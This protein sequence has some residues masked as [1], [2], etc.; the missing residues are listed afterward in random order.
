MLGYL[1]RVAKAEFQL[2]GEVDS[3]RWIPLQQ[4]HLLGPKSETS[5]AQQLIRACQARLKDEFSSQPTNFD[6]IVGEN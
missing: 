5:A 3:A 1:A 2:S 6:E 4:A